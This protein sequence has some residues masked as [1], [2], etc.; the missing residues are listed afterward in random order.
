M[1]RDGRSTGNSIM[2]WFASANSAARPVKLVID[3]KILP[4][5][6]LNEHFFS[7][8]ALARFLKQVAAAND[9]SRHEIIPPGIVMQHLD[10]GIDLPGA[11]LAAALQ[12]KQVTGRAL[13]LF[14]ESGRPAI[15]ASPGMI[16][17]SPLQIGSDSSV[18]IGDHHGFP[19]AIEQELIRAGD[20]VLCLGTS[21][22]QPGK[23]G[24]SYL[25]SHVIAMLD[26]LF[27][28]VP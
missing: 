9:S 28:S 8:L 6:V 16:T 17:S 14:H 7:E 3:G 18:F 2:A 27:S 22:P 12:E 19:A 4:G 13:V 23:E 24:I 15:A 26:V 25:G 1:L 5:Q 21:I 20:L 11:F 10:Q